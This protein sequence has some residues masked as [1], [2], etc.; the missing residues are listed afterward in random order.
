MSNCGVQ[1]S[2]NLNERDRLK[3][4]IKLDNQDN[5]FRANSELPLLDLRGVNIF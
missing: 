3:R 4:Q 1:K 5:R 2:K